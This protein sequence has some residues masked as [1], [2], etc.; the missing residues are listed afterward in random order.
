MGSVFRPRP[1]APP[2]APAPIAVAPTVAEVSQSTATSADGYDSRKT[3]AK[4][5]S[6]TIMTSAKGVEDETLACGT[7]VT[8]VAIAMY[9]TKK[10]TS[11]LICLPVEGGVLEVSF[12]EE[13]GNYKDV[14]LQGPATFV[15]KGIIQI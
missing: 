14:Y 1:P 11:N 6:Q 2:P 12:T 5:R 15:F 9:K 8:A 7:G 3:K 4:G 13:N 10:T